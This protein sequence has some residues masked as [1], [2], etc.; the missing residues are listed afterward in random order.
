[1]KVYD[2]AAMIADKSDAEIVPV[3]IEGLEQTPFSRLSKSQVRR[4][5]FPKVKVT[6]LEPVKLTVDPALKGRKR[7]LAAG[8]ALY[9]I[10]S[11]LV[12]RTTSTDRTVMEAVIQAAN[13]HGRSTI[14]IEDPVTGALTYKRVLAGAAILGAKLMPLAAEGRAIGVMLPNANGAAVTILGLM[15]AGRVPAM[16]NFTAGAANILAACTAAQIDTIVSSRTFIEKGKLTNLVAELEKVVK[17]VHLEDIRAT[18]TSGDKD[19]RPAQCQQAAGRA[20]AR[21]LGSDS[22]HLGLRRRAQGR[23]ALPPQHAGERRAGRRAHRLR[24]RGQGV[25][26]AAGVPLVRADGRADPAARVRRAH[27]SLSVAAALSHG[28]GADLRSERHHH[29]RHRYFPQRLC[30][31]RACLTTSARCATSSPA[32]SR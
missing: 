12:F 28:G 3:R 4:K 21:R 17:I 10:M 32:P 19:P 27:L 5:W 20:Q 15:S 18:V 30:A 8:A 6:I 16:I 31:G 11:D 2:G 29:V 25:Q 14:A 23:R 22:V 7:R 24:P 1:M 9:G 26:C 13:T